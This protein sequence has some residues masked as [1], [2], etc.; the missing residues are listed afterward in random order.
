[1]DVKE[2]YYLEIADSAFILSHRLAE[3]CSRGPYL[4]EDLAGTNNAL[5]LIGLAESLYTEAAK[6]HEAGMSADDLAY[7]RSEG[8]Y[9]NYLLCE[10]PN[11]DFAWIMTR[12]FFMDVFHYYFFSELIRSSDAFL[13]AVAHKT[14]KEVTYHLK[15]SS[16]W[17][18][19]FG[20]GTETSRLKAQNAIDGLWKYTGE[21][22]TASN[23]DTCLRALHVSA[24][25][26]VVRAK[27][28]QKVNE[29]FYLANL[30]KPSNDYQVLG[31]KSGIHSEYMGHMLSDIQF[32][33][34]KYPEAIW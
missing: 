16:E 13:Q 21:L 23:A 29:V 12:Q 25:L 10:Q 30:K 1:M 4:E 7:R 11:T 5:D 19:R 18:V 14:L 31:G 20:G 32:L 6:M 8:D 9:Y 27:W 34:N 24:D 22:F 33:T 3:C 28:L 26:E 2:K 17:M 15:R